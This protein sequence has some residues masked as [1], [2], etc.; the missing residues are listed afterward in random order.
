MTFLVI[1][2][3]TGTPNRHLEV[4]LLIFID[5]RLHFGSLLGPTLGTFCYFSMF[6]GAEVGGSFQVHVSG[7][8]GMELIPECSGC[9]C[10]N[11]T[12]NSGFLVVSL[13]PLIH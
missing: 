8:P 2:G 4:Q 9:M 12:K 3:S 13:F 7:D 5:F 11:A 10:L 6:L 1:Q